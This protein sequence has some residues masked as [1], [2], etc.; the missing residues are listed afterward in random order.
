MQPGLQTA[1]AAADREGEGSARERASGPACSLTG[2]GT[3]HAQGTFC[4]VNSNKVR[5]RW[6]GHGCSSNGQLRMCDWR[7]CLEHV[8][9]VSL[10]AGGVANNL[11]D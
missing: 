7:C 11:H 8:Q 1:A 6:P 3:V 2:N 9:L 5:V 10:L 4:Y